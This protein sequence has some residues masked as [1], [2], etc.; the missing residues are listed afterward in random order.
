MY[1]VSKGVKKR[2]QRE[3]YLRGDDSKQKKP[4]I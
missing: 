4:G 1:L 2:R 3:V